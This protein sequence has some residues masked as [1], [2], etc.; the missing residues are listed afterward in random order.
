MVYMDLYQVLYIYIIAVSLVG[1]FWGGGGLLSMRTS[2]SLT[3]VLSLGTC[4][5]LLGCQI[6]NFNTIVLSHLIL[7][8]DV[9]LLFLRDMLFSNERK[10]VSVSRGKWWWGVRKKLEVERRETII[11]NCCMKK[12]N[13]ISIKEIKMM[14]IKDAVTDQQRHWNFTWAQGEY[15]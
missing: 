11:I 14:T 15:L 12:I 9:W 7:F 5:L 1:F 8:W 3:L 10:Q 6:N 2:G 4:F 13:L